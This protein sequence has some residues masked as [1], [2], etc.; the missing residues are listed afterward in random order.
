MSDEEKRRKARESAELRYWF[1]WHVI[2]Y[3]II[4]AGFFALWYLYGTIDFIWPLIPVGFWFIGLIAHY[5]T[6]Y[7]SVGRSWIDK[8]TD[9]ILEDSS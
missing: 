6:A 5:L 3:L 2:L 1:R 7:R 9:K 4:N 8:E